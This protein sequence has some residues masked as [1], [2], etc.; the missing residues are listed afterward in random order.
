M[1][2]VD[3]N[4]TLTGALTFSRQ[5]RVDQQWWYRAWSFYLSDSV[6]S[7][8]KFRS[9]TKM[10]WIANSPPISNISS[11]SDIVASTIMTSSTMLATLFP[12]M[13]YTLPNQQ[14]NVIYLNR[15]IDHDRIRSFA[16]NVS[17]SQQLTD[18]IPVICSRLSV[19]RSRC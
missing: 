8:G 18:C 19:T 13:S 10:R 3:L 5:R 16:V 1:M 7:S 17:Q 9:H 15:I 2:Y 4:V 12:L 11:L 6:E 14:T